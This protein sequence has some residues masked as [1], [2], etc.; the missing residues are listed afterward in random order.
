MARPKRATIMA[1]CAGEA[2]LAA[3]E[4][5]NKP[6]VEFREQTVA[7]LIV[8]AWEVL[9]K[10]RIVQQSGG[11]VQSIYQRKRNSNR[12]KYSDDGDVLTINL[13][14]ALNRST[15]PDDVQGSR[16]V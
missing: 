10:A 3:V 14:G 7:F 15:L 6:K 12:F 11:K 9:L 16:H 1:R 13:K 4:I 2:L 8:N 5:Y